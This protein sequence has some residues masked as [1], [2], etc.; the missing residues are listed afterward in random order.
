VLWKIKKEISKDNNLFRIDTESKVIR[1]PDIL[2]PNVFSYFSAK[3]KEFNGFRELDKDNDIV[4]FKYITVT[5]KMANSIIEKIQKVKKSKE[6]KEKEKQILKE[7]FEKG[8]ITRE[9]Y[10][11]RY[12]LASIPPE[13]KVHDLIIK[14]LAKHYYLPL[15]MSEKDKIDYIKHIIKV[16]SELIFL[17][18]LVKNQNIFN[19][20]DWWY[21]SKL[22]ETLDK[23]FIPYYDGISRKI[24]AFV[25]DFI[26]WLKKG[27][28]LIILFIDPHGTEHTEAS[29]KIDG[30]REIFEDKDGNPK[31]FN[32][33]GLKIKVILRFYNE[34]I[35]AVPEQYTKYYINDVKD[36]ESILSREKKE[37]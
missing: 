37:Y 21:F 29:R 10:G 28:E 33:N 34:N 1:N 19:E 20:C 12:A 22:N 8:E 16:P 23:I 6:Q 9:Q 17:E 3:V 14:N 35:H 5:K 32:K 15:I 7:K 36:L 26:F 11:E 31:I 18:N 13:E 24:R 27:D 30:Y 4:H 25:P 2:L